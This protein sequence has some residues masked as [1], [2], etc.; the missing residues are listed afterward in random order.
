MKVMKFGG[1]SVRNAERISGVTAIIRDALADDSVAVVVSALGGV[2][3]TLLDAATLAESALGGV[4]SVDEK[5]DEL[6]RRHAEV[7][8]ALVMPEDRMVV[9]RRIGEGM[10]ELRDLLK[11]VAL[12]GECSPRTRDKIV[13]FG[14]RLSAILVAAALRSCGVD[15]EDCD[16]RDLIR[17]DNNFGH[18]LVDQ[19]VTYRNLREHF[20]NA[21]RLQ[22]VTG[23]IARGPGGETTTLGRSGSDLTAALVGA[24]LDAGAIEIWTDVDGVMST[25]PRLVPEAFSLPTLTY[26]ELMELSHF[27]A[28]VVFPPTVSPARDRNIPLLIK[29]TLNPSFPGTRIDTRRGDDTERERAIAPNGETAAITGIASISLVTMISLEGEGMMGV[30]GIAARLF[31]ALAAEKISII[32]ISQASSE[33][34]ICF[35][36]APTQTAAAEQAVNR[37][38]KTEMEHGLIDPLNIEEDCSVVAI[39]GETMRHRPGI[40][41]RLFR[42]LGRRNINV[43]AIAQGSSERNISLI[44][45]HQDEV[46]AVRAIHESFFH[47]DDRALKL[48]LAGVGGVG[49]ALVDQLRERTGPL[50]DRGI[51]LRVIGLA[52]SKH[53]LFDSAGLSLDKF[54]AQS[55]LREQLASAAGGSG[56]ATDLEVVVHNLIEAV[57]P[58][59][60]VDCTASPDV[61]ALYPRLLSAGVRVITANK[62]SLAGAAEL[63]P[64]AL[65]HR[66]TGLYYEATAGAGLPIVRTVQGLVGGGDD[67]RR[68]EGAFSGTLSFLMSALRS[69]QKFSDAVKEADRLGYTEP[70]PRED[71]SG[72]DVAR[73]LVILAREAGHSIE[74]SDLAVEPLYDPSFGALSIEQFWSR[75][76]EL[77]QPMAERIEQARAAGQTLSYLASFAVDPETGRGQGRVG[78]QRVELSHPAASVEGTDNL[79]AF[80]TRY[81]DSTPMV[82]RGPGAGTAVTAGGLFADILRA[83]AESVRSG[84]DCD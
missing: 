75:L 71:L 44:I 52:S 53:T 22:V 18:A 78:L 83:H 12:L 26:E 54:D 61:A 15:A 16:A 50:R 77:D 21:R 24:A 57:G 55:P 40:A 41:G 7:T 25:D 56:E 23:F 20:A 69:G 46:A 47:H 79:F 64:R 74:L 29:N 80:A 19:D 70:D 36:I 67:I 73:K 65:H 31:D 8:E 63:D 45:A 17:T 42:L 10:A 82:I 84:T 3:D 49:S 68:I 34:S 51:D 59:A 72:M 33:H 1:S 58:R 60:L 38:F 5:L 6:E 30:P 76:P 43:R 2:T 13:S 48:F 37:R 35:A 62:V 14:E 66:P 39:V 32:L 11:G 4:G 81:Y 27:G 9:R 28:K